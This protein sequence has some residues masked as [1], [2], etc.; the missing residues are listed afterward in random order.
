MRIR[1]SDGGRIRNGLSGINVSIINKIRGRRSM[2]DMIMKTDRLI[3]RKMR[4]DDAENLLEIFS[5]PI[6]MEYYPSTKN[7][8]QT[9]QWID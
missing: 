2:K 3:L 1:R 6:A 7:E 5:D 8:K 4:R 9:L